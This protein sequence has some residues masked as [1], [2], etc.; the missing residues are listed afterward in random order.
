MIATSPAVLAVST[1]SVPQPST[2]G[3]PTPP[4]T[5]R[6]AAPGSG[7]T[8]ALT[9][10]DG[11]GAS[12]AALLDI[13]ERQHVTAS[14]F[15]LGSVE[16]TDPARVRSE[17]RDGFALGD[18]TWSHSDLS[19]LD[20]AGQAREIDHARRREARITGH[21]T[22]LLRPPFGNYDATTLR[23]A[24]ERHL[25]IWTWSV[26][27]EDW[28]AAGAS[29]PY[30]VNRI[31]TRAEAGGMQRHPVVLMHNQTVGNPATVLALPHIIRYYRQHRYRFVDLNGNT[32]RPT[33]SQLSASSGSTAGRYRLVV[34]GTNFRRIAAVRFGV[35]A[36][37]RF[38]VHSPRRLV[39]TVPPHRRGTVAVTVRT[40]DHG[41]SPAS[42]AARF[43]FGKSGAAS[44]RS[45]QRIQ[46]QREITS[47]RRAGPSRS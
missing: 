10:D 1:G 38:T 9:F 39:V 2:Y 8:V 21:H 34:R 46:P 14:F 29:S 26:D 11:P 40:A 42:A 44:G 30:W 27:T 31:V 24:R 47:G 45:R 5:V 19:R 25:A 33:V 20:A 12:T 22:C 3:C 6:S 41:D 36:A 15:N 4:R 37:P 23:L 35:I 13:L 17:M 16:I 28:K 43:R 32:G 18:H 7:K